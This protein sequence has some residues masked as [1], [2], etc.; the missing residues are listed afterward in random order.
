[1][2][3]LMYFN[4]CYFWLFE[5]NNMTLLVFI[6]KMP[7]PEDHKMK[8]LNLMTFLLEMMSYQLFFLTQDF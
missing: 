1:M 3:T 4:H 6:I 7:F 2:K 8:L 5:D